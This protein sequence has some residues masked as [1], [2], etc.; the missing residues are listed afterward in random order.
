MFQLTLNK[1]KKARTSTSLGTWK[2]NIE[3]FVRFR[4]EKFVLKK[5]SS[6]GTFLKTKRIPDDET[7]TDVVDGLR[8]SLT[9][10][11]AGKC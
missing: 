2:T 11:V 6:C 9:F 5:S 7:R 8:D 3:L 4:I 10:K 1:F